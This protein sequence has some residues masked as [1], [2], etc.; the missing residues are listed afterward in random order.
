[1]MFVNVALKLLKGGFFDIVA[2]YYD[3]YKNN[4]LK[5]KQQ[6]VYEALF[7]LNIIL[8]FKLLLV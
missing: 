8:C 5:I 2:N 7:I 4:E 6:F 3:Y 1:M